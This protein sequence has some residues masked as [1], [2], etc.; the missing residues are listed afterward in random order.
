MTNKAYYWVGDF[1]KN[2]MKISA[3]LCAEIV[4]AVKAGA[5]KETIYQGIEAFSCLSGYE[6][7]I[8]TKS[9]KEEHGN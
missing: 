9:Y 1:I 4:K 7:Y 6:D 2:N 3:A 8:L 5:P